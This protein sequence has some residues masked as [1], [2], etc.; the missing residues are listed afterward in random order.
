MVVEHRIA[1]VHLA[2]A[3]DVGYI[4]SQSLRGSEG[5]QR[6]ARGNTS[7]ARLLALQGIST[8]YY[9]I[10]HTGR[11][12]CSESLMMILGSLTRH[13]QIGTVRATPGYLPT[14]SPTP[15]WPFSPLMSI[16]HSPLMSIV[17]STLMTRVGRLLGEH[18][19]TLP[20]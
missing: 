20:S 12:T 9:R 15:C 16:V 3:I 17:H 1:Q 7:L 5:P 8:S 14:S 10:I 18:H 11:S 4:L 6:T 13:A 19:G 2:A